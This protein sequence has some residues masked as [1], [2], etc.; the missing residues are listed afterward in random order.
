MAKVVP[1]KSF[2]GMD[3][4]MTKKLQIPKIQAEEFLI[5]VEKDV[6]FLQAQEIMDY[7]LLIGICEKGDQEIE[8]GKKKAGNFF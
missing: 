5:Q 6:K 8:K 2:L 4:N 3:Q 7:S 1:G